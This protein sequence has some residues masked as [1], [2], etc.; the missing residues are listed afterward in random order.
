[1][2]YEIFESRSP[3][4]G[5][6]GLSIKPNGAIR[7]NADVG[8]ILKERGAEHVL[9]L[10]DKRKRKMAIS[11][12]PKSDSRAY[13]LKYDARGSGATFAAKAFAKYIGWNSSRSMML[14]VKISDEMLEVTLPQENL[15]EP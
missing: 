3:Q 8:K 12:A 10:W 7:L 4:T 9:I 13:K 15:H 14:P 1:M 2:G 5:K 11:I 6:P